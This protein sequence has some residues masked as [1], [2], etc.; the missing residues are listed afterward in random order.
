MIRASL[1]HFDGKKD[2]WSIPSGTF[3][4][5]LGTSATDDSQQASLHLSGRTFAP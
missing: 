5:W 4:L 2:R 3:R 1:A